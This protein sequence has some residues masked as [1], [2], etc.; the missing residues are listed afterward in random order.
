MSKNPQTLSKH[1]IERSFSIPAVFGLW[2][3]L[4]VLLG[5]LYHINLAVSPATSLQDIPLWAM[6]GSAST[7][8]IALI[9]RPRILGLSKLTCSI[10][11]FVTA[12][13]VGYLLANIALL[14]TGETLAEEWSHW[15]YRYLFFWAGVPACEEV[16]CRGVLLASL[17]TRM[18]AWSAVLL[19]SLLIA[20]CHDSITN[21]LLGQIGIGI[22]YVLCRRSLAA[23]FVAHSV[24]NIAVTSRHLLL[25]NLFVKHNAH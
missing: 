10:W 18:S 15:G 25:A 3:F 11:E 20:L 12:V 21:A 14:V 22:I 7:V 2:L 24:A 17:L 1:E 4:A 23:S 13:G 8:A 9:F 6:I 5:V 19:S 16:F